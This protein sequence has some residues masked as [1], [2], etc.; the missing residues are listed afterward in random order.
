[1]NLTQNALA[2]GAMKSAVS[3]ACGVILA[4]F[5]ATGN[6]VFSWPWFRQVIIQIFFVIVVAEARF[7]KQWSE[8]SGNGGS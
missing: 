4:N 1:M 7:W 5:V 6:V 3:A 8:S 2:G